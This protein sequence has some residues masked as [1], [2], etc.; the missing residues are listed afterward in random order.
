MLRAGNFVC[1][2]SVSWS[3]TA[4]T[5]LAGIWVFYQCGISSSKIE[6]TVYSHF[7]HLKNCMLP[8]NNI[9]CSDSFSQSVAERTIM[10]RIWVSY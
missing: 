4:L 10:A 3:V 2:N 9:I 6:I 5:I 7:F 8:D 1:C